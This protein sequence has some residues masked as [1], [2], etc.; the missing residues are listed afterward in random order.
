ME[1][2]YASNAVRPGHRVFSL[3]SPGD[4]DEE[5]DEP[6]TPFLIVFE[7]QNAHS[8]AIDEL[9]TQKQMWRLRRYRKDFV[10]ELLPRFDKL[11]TACVGHIEICCTNTAS[12]GIL[13]RTPGVLL[14]YIHR[15]TILA[16]VAWFRCKDIPG[17]IIEEIR[18]RP[19][20]DRLCRCPANARIVMVPRPR[21]RE[22]ISIESSEEPIEVR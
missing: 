4:G 12:M 7:D 22:E 10:D 11:V 13:R 15:V 17:Y 21:D 18:A 2:Y 20:T 1:C 3:S 19:A 5:S 16:L 8:R 6:I 14:V 9:I